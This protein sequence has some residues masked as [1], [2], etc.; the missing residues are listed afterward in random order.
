MKK[1]I[2]VTLALV[3]LAGIGFAYSAGYCLKCN[4]HQ[5]Y[6]GSSWNDRCTTCGHERAEHS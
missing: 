3:L 1:F 2:L 6:G 5:Y 4:C